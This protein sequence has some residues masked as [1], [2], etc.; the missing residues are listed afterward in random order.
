MYFTLKPD[1]AIPSRSLPSASPLLTTTMLP[2]TTLKNPT[3]DSFFLKD[4]IIS[5]RKKS[6]IVLE[7]DKL[8]DS[9]TEKVRDLNA[10]SA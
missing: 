10:K 2:P 8:A 4:D 1:S 9:D 7:V 3:N 5:K 6:H